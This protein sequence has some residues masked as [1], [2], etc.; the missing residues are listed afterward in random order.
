M[1]DIRTRS[2][3]GYAD[4]FSVAPGERIAFK[5]S[6]MGHAH[7]QAD[8][9]RLVSGDLS[10]TGPGFREELV[11]TGIAGVYP[12][13]LQ[14]IAAGSYALVPD[15]P[16]L[17]GISDFSVVAMVWPT[18]PGHG[19]QVLLS[20]RSRSGG[21]DL[22]INAG[23]A[24]ALVLDNGRGA[25]AEYS[26][27]RPLLSREWYFVAAIFDAAKGQVTLIQEPLIA[28]ARADG[29][30]V[31]VLPATVALGEAATDLTIAAA[32]EPL[33]FGHRAFAHYN[34]KIDSPR[35]YRAAL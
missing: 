14:E 2:I 25:V 10:P 27:G 28:Y 18:M 12:G 8:I 5:V 32:L 3:L 31:R 6:S 7:Y 26:T 20:R 11:P 1:T 16:A 23:G 35:L 15:R 19:S 4:R 13:R 21:F 24:L 9:V 34:G 33:Q 29:A 30:A 22:A 17:H